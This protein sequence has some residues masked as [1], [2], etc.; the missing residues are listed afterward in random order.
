[1]SGDTLARLGGDEFA[2]LLDGAGETQ[3]TSLA[4]RYIERLNE[5]VTVG[6]R[7]L[8][9]NAS[10]GIAVHTGGSCTGEELVRRADVAM[11]AAKRSG[12]GR[13]EVYRPEMAQTVGDLFG[14]EHNLREGLRHN[15]FV[16]HYQPEVDMASDRI[17]GVEALVRWH[18][19]TH[20][21]VL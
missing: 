9:V 8:S 13:C 16:V 18:S 6:D 21:I 7:E 5:P 17:V 2:V 20:G 11:Y 3:A 4:G 19:A 15:E 1:R 14:L 10:I 12:G